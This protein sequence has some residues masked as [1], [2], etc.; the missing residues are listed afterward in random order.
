VILNLMLA[1]GLMAACVAIHAVGV[2]AALE[3]LRVQREPA[4]HFWRETWLFIRLTTWMVLLHLAEIA[5]WAVTYA[6]AGVM[7]GLQSAF[8]FSAVPTRLQAMATWCCL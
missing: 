4:L 7:P 2:T 6:A 5:V 1:F 3:R 8:Y